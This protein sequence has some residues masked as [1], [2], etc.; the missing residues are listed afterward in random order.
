MSDIKKAL[1]AITKTDDEVY[2]IVG[3]VTKVD[4]KRRVVN[5]QPLNGDAEILGVKLQSNESDTEG[6][7]IFPQK[8]SNVVVTFLNKN[9][10]YVAM[11][12]SVEMVEYIAQNLKIS[13][14]TEGVHVE[15]NGAD[16]KKIVDT[17]VEHTDTVYDFL[18]KLKIVTPSGLGKL[19]PDMI[20]LVKAEQLKLT[21]L[22]NQISQILK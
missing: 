10:G 17:L 5:V 1:R 6:L 16:L 22:K 18:I 3:E 15:R 19:S 21:T 4:K 20:L 11:V 12:S 14:D 13:L 9:T 2:S 8:G 7:V